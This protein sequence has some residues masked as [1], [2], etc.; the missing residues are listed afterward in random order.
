L[1]NLKEYIDYYKEGDRVVFT[2]LFHSK[3][4]YCCANKCRHCPYIPKHIK[5]STEMNLNEL[6][7]LKKQADALELNENGLSETDK[8]NEAIKIFEQLNVLLK[9][10][11]VNN[12]ETEQE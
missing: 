2:A 3:R 4:G 1:P 7:N 11:E 5:Y 9:D 8:M 6:E 10:L 12:Q